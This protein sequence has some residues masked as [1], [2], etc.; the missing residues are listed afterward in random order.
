MK[1]VA[2]QGSPRKNGNTFFALTVI[3]NILVEEGI[4]FEIIDI[5]GKHIRGC[6]ACEKCY[7]NRDGK[8]AVTND[9][10]NDT[11]AKMKTADGI[12]IASPVYYSGIAG[13]MKCFLDRAFYVAEVNGG[14]F[15]HKVGAS[16][17]AVRRT[18]GSMT[19]NSL[20]HYL[21]IA[22]MLIPASNYWNVIHG[23]L[24]GDAAKDKEGIQIMQMLAKNMA[25]LLK[26]RE[27]TKNMEPKQSE[28]IFTNFI[29]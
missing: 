8:C 3:K 27:R 26:M 20:N 10:V 23:L 14:W 24:P 6:T 12:I 4:D 15:R 21:G 7:E 28:K 29:R 2:I 1:V 17:V 13:T 18:G 22:E 9:A 5:G 16:V 11:V 19:F 25:W